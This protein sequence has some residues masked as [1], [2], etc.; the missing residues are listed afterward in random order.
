MVRIR[1]PAAPSAGSRLCAL[2]RSGR[3]DNFGVKRPPVIPEFAQQISGNSQWSGSDHLR[4]RLRGPGSATPAGMTL[5]TDMAT[6]MIHRRSRPRLDEHPPLSSRN[7]REQ[8]S[9]NSRWPVICSPA[10]DDASFADIANGSGSQISRRTRA[11]LLRAA[12]IRL[13]ARLQQ[14]LDR[15][16]FARRHFRPAAEFLKRAETAHAHRLRGIDETDLDAGRPD[17]SLHGRKL[18]RARALRKSGWPIAP[19]SLFC[20]FVTG[21]GASAPFVSGE[22]RT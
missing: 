22:W 16:A 12:F 18:A 15:F 19:D 10:W 21:N 17:I 4:R 5:F 13:A 20:G 7:L 9:G 8:I 11:P 2:A 14:G 6:G 3:D 1:S